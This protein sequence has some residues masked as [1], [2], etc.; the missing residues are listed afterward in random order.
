MPEKRRKSE[1]AAKLAQK[2]TDA[3]WAKNNETH[4]GY[5]DRVKCDA[6]SKL[7]THYRVTDDSQHSTVL[8]DDRDEACYADSVHSS[9][10]IANNLP[11]NCANQICGTGHR[12]KNYYQK[13]S[14][15]KKSEILCRIEHIRGK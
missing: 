1:N 11:K 8:F 10:E 4:F 7:V 12:G 3:R 6:D 9:A 2:D 13:E 15:R 5:K 14:D